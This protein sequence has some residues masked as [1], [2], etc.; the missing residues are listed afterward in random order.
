MG[1]A[2]RCGDHCDRI[3]ILKKTLV[4][5]L[6]F[7]GKHKLFA[8][9]QKDPFGFFGFFGKT[10]CFVILYLVHSERAAFLLSAFSKNVNW[11]EHEIF[12][13]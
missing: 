4:F 10:R 6:V 7:W 1:E 5:F 12:V 2:I 8:R 3:P 9:F 11:T 13:L